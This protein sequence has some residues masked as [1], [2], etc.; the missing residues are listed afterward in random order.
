M[1]FDKIVA[2]IIPIKLPNAK[3]PI[4]ATIA[5][6]IIALF[7]SAEATAGIN[8]GLMIPATDVK[9]KVSLSILKIQTKRKCNKNE[10]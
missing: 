5:G 7:L 9:I 6:T 4:E 3:P 1:Y 10:P 8:G 2:N